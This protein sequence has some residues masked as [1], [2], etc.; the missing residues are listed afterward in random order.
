MFRKLHTLHRLVLVFKD[1]NRF[2]PVMETRT[3]N[4]VCGDGYWDDDF[5]RHW[6]IVRLADGAVRSIGDYFVPEIYRETYSRCD[7]HPRWRRDGCTLAF[8]SDHEG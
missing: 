6:K 1:G 8:N 5:F 3:L 4:F 7:L 2:L